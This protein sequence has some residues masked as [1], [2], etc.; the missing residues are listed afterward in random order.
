MGKDDS[1]RESFFARLRR[2]RRRPEEPEGLKPSI[3]ERKRIDNVVVGA[4]GDKDEENIQTFNNSNIT[5][6]SGLGD[7][8]FD[9]ILRD[10]QRNIVSLYQ[11]ADYYSDSDALIHGIIHHIY[12][13]YTLSS[14]WALTGANEKTYKIYEEYYDKIRLREKL[15]SIA[16]EYWK[17]GNVFVY[18]YN[19]VPITLPVHKCKIGNVALNGE[20]VVDFDCQSIYN[21]WRAKSYSVKENW[22]KDN[23][24][25]T[26][27]KGY[28]PEVQK[29]LNSGVQYAQLD[30]KYCKVLQGPKEGWQRYAIPFIASC[31]HALSRKELISDYESSV[32]NLGI[33]SFVHVKYG[34]PKKEMLPDSRQLTEV[35][36]IFSKAMAGFPLAVTNHLADTDVV[37]PKLDDLFQ[38]DKYRDV[39]N[40]ILSAGGVSGM[41]VTGVSEDGSTFASAQVSMETVA[42]RIEAARDE[43][44]D[45]MNRINVCI[46]EKLA[47]QH[48]YNIKKVPEFYFKP[49]D[50]NGR[51]SLREACEQLWIKGLV[52]TKTYMEMNGYS[53]DHEKELRMREA[54]D[55]TDEVL[56][57]REEQRAVN[58]AA[59]NEPTNDSPDDASE[60]TRGRD[61]LDDDERKSD[62]ES[63]KRGAQPKPS[64]PEGSEGSNEIT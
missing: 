20:P 37:Q 4:R 49:L 26:Y 64:N 45:L 57:P 17:Y 28:P 39:N 2:R 62:P 46:Q 32:L 54:E 44:C 35:R 58:S 60:E 18:I 15:D 22:I 12:K 14:G 27:F 53:T 50:M 55:G 56:V 33:R 48:I 9:S 21:E 30:P 16:L 25:E 7:Y 63:A 31:L 24:L 47:E 38:F 29:A 1:R 13:P 51:K 8:D 11:L 42:A 34:D 43:I 36:R 52:S 23:K 40:D 10:K 41:L 61:S 19:G 3:E 5:F 59:D 6:A